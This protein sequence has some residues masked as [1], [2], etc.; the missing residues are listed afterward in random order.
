MAFLASDE[1]ANVTGLYLGID[2]PRIT[3]WEPNLPG[4]A[5]FAY[6]QWTAEDIARGWHRS[7]NADLLLERRRA[8]S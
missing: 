8:M 3:V 1:A 7:S 5:V 4:T 2:G 6:P